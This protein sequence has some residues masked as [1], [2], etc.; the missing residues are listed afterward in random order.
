MSDVIGYS[1]QAG[2]QQSEV[3]NEALAVWMQRSMLIP[4]F[5]YYNRLVLLLRLPSTGLPLLLLSRLLL[6]L[7]PPPIIIIIIIIIKVKVK[8]KFTLEQA[9]KGHRGS[10]GTALLFLYPRR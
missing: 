4:Y 6:Q 10:R 7:P 1:Q 8:V 5:H 2:T 3:H 9:T